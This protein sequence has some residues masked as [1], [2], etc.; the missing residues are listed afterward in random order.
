MILS[1]WIEYISLLIV[2]CYN[3]SL[4]HTVINNYLSVVE[5]KKRSECIESL[6]DCLV[7][8]LHSRDG[9]MAALHCLW[10][11]SP[12]DRKSIVKSLKT[13][14]EKTA[15]EE[16]G[17]LVLLAIFDTIDDTKLVG[18]AI[19][20]EIC[21]SLD[22]IMNNKFGLRVVKYLVAGRDKA[23]TYPEVVATLQRGDG[24]EH[25]KKEAGLRRRELCQAAAGPLLTWLTERLQAGLYDPPSTITFTC[26]L[27][28][29]PASEQLTS[30]WR[31]LAAEAVKPFSSGDDAPNIIES[32]ASN[33]MLK[34]IIQKDGSRAAV[35]EETL[36]A[37]LLGAV[38][39]A[40]L[41]AW[42]G[43]NRGA[44]LLVWC[45]ETDVPGIRTLVTEKMTK[46]EFSLASTLNK[47]THKGAAILKEKLKI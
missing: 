17:H 9:A 14:V 2:G 24:N 11:G 20:G 10:H 21:D 22:R 19:V 46:G 37:V 28:H 23:Y 40:G 25:S 32:R 12:K 16:Y 33:M 45:W 7:H 29:M 31:L 3:H 5:G 8:M 41:E 44:L 18:K 6:R 43:C 4:V 13:L 1:C 30:I 35:E 47:Q 38:G 34:K 36:S 42:L 27:N 39:E 26:I 15:Y